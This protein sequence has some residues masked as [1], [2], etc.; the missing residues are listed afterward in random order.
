[1]NKINL[2]ESEKLFNDFLSKLKYKE[3][4]KKYFNNPII[5]N[6]T[7][8]VNI[9]NKLDINKLFN[10]IIL[11]NILINKIY[12]NK[13][14]FLRLSININEKEHKNPINIKIFSNGKMLITGCKSNN[15]LNKVIIIVLD[16]LNINKKLQDIDIKT[17]LIN[18]RMNINQEIDLYKVYDY[19][20]EKYTDNQIH[21]N[22]ENNTKMIITLKL[23]NK[24]IN[25]KIKSPTIILYNSGSVNIFC[26]S[27]KIL[28]KIENFIKDLFNDNYYKLISRDY[29]I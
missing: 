12:D 25:K 4:E 20:S 15:E 13:Q 8:I 17:S 23:Y 16:K 28:S 18:A 7:N 11:D 9:N 26:I 19:L 1:M 2:E 22:T 10:F 6:T 24:I 14:K 21:L 3:V 5:N 27:Y 29:L